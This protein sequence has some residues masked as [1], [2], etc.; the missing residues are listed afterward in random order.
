[1]ATA[2]PPPDRI[3]RLADRLAVARQRRFVGRVGELESFRSA[4]LSDDPPF[5]VM[6]LHGPGGVGKTALLGEFVR[7]AAEHDLSALLLDGR[8]IEPT[9]TGFLRALGLTLGLPADTSPLEALTQCAPGVLLIDTY[10]ALAPL[11]GW[12]R[13]TF[14][15]ELPGATLVVIAGRNLPAAAWRTE[16]GWR[17]L[18]RVLSVR[19][20]RPEESRAYLRRRGVPETQFAA[21]LDATHGHPLALSLVADV[22]AESET[23]TMVSLVQE[24]GV[25]RVLLERFAQHAPSDRHRQALEA[26]AHIRATTEDVL[27]EALAATDAEAHKLF[28]WLAGL[29]F[30][31]HGPEGLFPHDLARD[32]LDL[33]QRW[34]NPEAYARLRRQVRAVFIRRLQQARGMEQQRAFFDLL[35]LHRNHPLMRPFY[36]WQSLASSYADQATAIDGPA[37]LAMVERHE[38]KA[39]ARIAAHWLERQPQGCIVLRGLGGGVTGFIAHVA[40]HEATPDDRQVDPAVNATLTFTER[41]GQVRPGEALLLSRFLVDRDAYQ[42]VSPTFNAMAMTS[43]MRW[44]TTPRLAWNLIAV[45]D[46]EKMRPTF[47]YINMR[48][49]PAADFEVGDCRYAVFAHDWRAESP[50]VWLEAMGDRELATELTAESIEAM[51]PPLVVLSRPDFQEAVRRALRD[52]Q[53]PAALAANPLLRSRLVQ[54]AAGGVP[55]PQALQHLLRAAVATLQA[56]PKDE[57]LYRVLRRT[58]MEPAGTQEAVAELLGLPLG[59]Y[60]SQLAAAIERVTERL[61]QQELSGAAG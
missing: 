19:N 14:L 17:D 32:V 34:R 44:V 26:C 52:F 40:L 54:E 13:D 22:L 8:S 41:F 48:R 31:E 43:T 55:D 29:S 51:A 3:V 9:P 21:A 16:P 15:P 49:T 33:D 2:E 38:G 4:L 60:R 12:L 37:I 27:A 59:T 10:E 28:A 7:I 23:S 35:Y 11:D 57:K 46:P 1:M 45:A 36:D 18:V 39:A 5:A 61:W 25:V 20:L 24:R 30:I 6:H 56:H 58:Y 50:L 53:R 47:S 42:G